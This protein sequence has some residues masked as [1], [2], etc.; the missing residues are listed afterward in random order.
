MTDS[1]LE[2]CLPWILG[3]NPYTYTFTKAIGELLLQDEKGDIP[4]AIVRP[5]IIVSSYAD[6]IPVSVIIRLIRKVR[7]HSAIL[8]R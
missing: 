7:S 3:N 2:V 1:E 5:S 4:A 6:P 8:R